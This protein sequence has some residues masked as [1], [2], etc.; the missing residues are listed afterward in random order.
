MA[1]LPAVLGRVLLIALWQNSVCIA[2]TSLTAYTVA[3][4]TP[5]GMGNRGPRAC[6]GTPSWSTAVRCFHHPGVKR[7]GHGSCIRGTG[8]DCGRR[9]RGP[10]RRS[11]VG[12]PWHSLVAG[13]TAPQHD[14]SSQ[15][16]RR[17]Y[18]DRRVMAAVGHG[19][20]RTRPCPA[21]GDLL[22]L[23]DVPGGRGSRPG[24]RQWESRSRVQS[25]YG[26]AGLTGRG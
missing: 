14:R 17:P 5:V 19:S 16:P 26:L 23:G 11:A 13:G 25:L 1:F 4:G 21:G 10:Q 8:V 20:R 15:G 22:Y 6:R 2:C 3:Q 18:P 7:Q 9:T 24:D 12:T